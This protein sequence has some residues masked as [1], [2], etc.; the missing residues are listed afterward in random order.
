MAGIR[1][2]LPRVRLRGGLL[3]GILKGVR[4]GKHLRLLLDAFIVSPL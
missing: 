4:N 1:I 2:P 3:K